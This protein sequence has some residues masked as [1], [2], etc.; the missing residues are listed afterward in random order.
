MKCYAIKKLVMSKGDNSQSATTFSEQQLHR[1]FERRK[2]PMKVFLGDKLWGRITPLLICRWRSSAIRKLSLKLV[3]TG[4][5]VVFSILYVVF[6]SID[7]FLLT[8]NNS[9]KLLKKNGIEVRKILFRFELIS[10]LTL[11]E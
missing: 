4:T 1:L 3:E 6:Y 9:A 11:T 8:L 7:V 2:R 5:S 10:W